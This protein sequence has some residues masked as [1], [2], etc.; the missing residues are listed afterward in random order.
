[1]WRTFDCEEHIFDEL[2]WFR[3]SKL[4]EI[5]NFVS[6]KSVQNP[7]F[8]SKLLLS[9]NLQVLTKKFSKFTNFDAFKLVEKPWLISTFYFCVPLAS[10]QQSKIT[11]L[12]HVPQLTLLSENTSKPF[13]TLIISNFVALTCICCCQTSRLVFWFISSPQLCFHSSSLRS[14]FSSIFLCEKQNKQNFS[15]HVAVSKFISFH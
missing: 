5:Y 1:M 7:E 9:K 13:S 14:Y 6:S 10:D 15:V 8:C 11:E 12:I 4:F 2:V 3:H